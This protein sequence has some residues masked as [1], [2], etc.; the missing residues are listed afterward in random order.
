MTFCDWEEI[1]SEQISDRYRRQVAMGENLLLARIELKAGAIAQ[2]HSH[3][4]AE[5]VTVLSGAWR[6]Y[7]PDR[8]VTLYPNQ[9][10]SIPPGVEHASEALE[11]TL[12]L[13]TCVPPRCAWLDE[14]HR[15][16][17]HSAEDS[18]WAV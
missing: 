2:P 14:E 10:L 17:S 11:E 12:A 8:E 15:A 3:H 4:N 1:K 13:S 7:L 6:F 9:V 16:H 5:I 18:L